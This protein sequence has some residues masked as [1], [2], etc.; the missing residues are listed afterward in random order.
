MK[1]AKITSTF[2]VSTTILLTSCATVQETINTYT[3]P[4][5]ETVATSDRQW[6]GIAVSQDNR[7]FVN[8][9]RWSDDVPI[10]VAELVDGKP[11]P[12]PNAAMN[13]WDEGKDPYSHFVCVQSVFI[14]DKNR[15]WILDPANPKFQGVVSGGAKLLQINLE[16]GEIE[17]SILFPSNITKE[18]SYLND[19]RIDTAR[20]VAYITDSG[21]GALIVA[22]MNTGVI[23]RLLDDHPSTEAEDV[24]LTIE[25]DQWLQNGEKREVHA[26]GIAYDAASDTVF[27]QAL[28]GRTMYS[29]SG[30]DLRNGSLTS[31]E[32]ASRVQVVGE[33]GASDGLIF[34]PD[35]KV[36]ISALEHNAIRRTTSSGE[37]ETV[38]SGEAISWPDSFS[39]GPNDSIYFT[40]AR[41][42]EGANPEA[43]YGIHRFKVR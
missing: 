8:Y 17:Q 36:Y 2:L 15:L 24:I 10:S 4:E 3:A 1:P 27:Y 38:V 12:Y 7:I 25:G 21:D 28:T 43:P 19:V 9:P 29:I 40:T 13:S 16:S 41:I 42:H 20:E 5:L 33:T 30:A 22:D 18:T 26:D 23:R 34:G 6:T 32:L 39:L 35:G 37:V 11:V 31:S 14:D